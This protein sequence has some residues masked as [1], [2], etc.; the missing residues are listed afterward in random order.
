MKKFVVLF[1]AFVLLTANQ[2]FAY[3]ATDFSNDSKIVAAINL[4][5]QAGET[6]IMAR[7]QKHAIRISFDD[8]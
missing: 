4:L 2:V 7:L 5:E 1:A 8:L 3:K 6:D